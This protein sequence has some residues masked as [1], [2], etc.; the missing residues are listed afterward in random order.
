MAPHTS[1]EPSA[2]VR[3]WHGLLGAEA[4]D[5]A[6]GQGRHSLW[7]ARQGCRVTAVDRDGPALA[8]LARQAQAYGLAE[9]VRTVEADIE[10]SPWPLS[11]QAFD[12]V[13]VTHYLWRP[14]WSHILAS[15]RA[16]G[17]LVYETFAAG[18]ASVGKP[19]RPDFLLRPGELLRVC[20]GWRIV[21]YEDGFLS[22][23][24]RYIQRIAAQRPPVPVAH[25]AGPLGDGAAPVPARIRLDAAG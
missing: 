12:A 6:C 1:A 5:L 4:L 22:A 8:A 14:L 18:N 9:R 13:I 23:P 2:W 7:L 10:N 19:S 25:D 21:A 24:D 3:R 15:V 20:E 11:G 16:G 17:V